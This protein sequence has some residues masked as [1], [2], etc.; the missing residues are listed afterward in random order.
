[1]TGALTLLGLFLAAFAAVMAGMPYLIR[2]LQNRAMLD[3]PNERSSHEIPTPRGAGWLALGTPILGLALIPGFVNLAP[4]WT[5]SVYALCAGLVALM[6]L[7]GLDDR[8]GL[9][10]KLRLLAHLAVSALV[11]FTLPEDVRILTVLPE[12]LERLL[13]VFGMVWMIN[14][15]NFIDGINGITAVNGLVA[16]FGLI[17]LGFA[18]HIPLLALPGALLA[19][20]LAA[21][22][23]F[24]WTPA[25]VFIGDVGSVP[26]GLWLGYSMILCAAS[27]G[28]SAAFLLYLYPILDAT[29]TLFKRAAKGEKIWEAHKTHF[30]Q[31]AVQ[32]GRTHN[33]TSL[34]IGAYNLIC[35]TLAFVAIVNPPLGWFCLAGGIVLF[36]LLARHFKKAA[37]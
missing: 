5:Y 28:V 11:V 33:R 36:V 2:F 10:P 13:A 20:A 23:Y 31:Q 1:M 17:L 18:A 8:R 12:T 29:Y 26:L 27:F 22:L 3:I 14:L 24:N 4:T 6:L 21:F 15:T 19:G 37:P 7:S 34:I 25:K 9:S 30:Y 16:A 32:N 35:V